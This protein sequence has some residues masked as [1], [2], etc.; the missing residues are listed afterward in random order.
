MMKSDVISRRGELLPD[1]RLTWNAAQ[2]C[3]ENAPDANAL[4]KSVYRDG[5]TLAGL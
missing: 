2:G 1:R 4:L 5:W 3:F